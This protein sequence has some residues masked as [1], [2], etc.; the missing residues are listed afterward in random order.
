MRFFLDDVDNSD[1]PSPQTN[2]FGDGWDSQEQIRLEMNAT[3]ACICPLGLL[4]A[5]CEINM[6]RSCKST[7]SSDCK[8]AATESLSY[9]LRHIR[10]ELAKCKSMYDMVETAKMS[11]DTLLL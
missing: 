10:K 11:C 3:P 1:D 5:K 7:A 2:C 9:L 8:N 4:D 6:D